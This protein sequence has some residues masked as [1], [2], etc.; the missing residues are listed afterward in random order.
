MVK[1]RVAKIFKLKDEYGYISPYQLEKRAKSKLPTFRFRNR[2][3][4]L[5][6]IEGV[7]ENTRYP[8]YPIHISCLYNDILR[9]SDTHHFYSCF[10]ADRSENIQPFLRCVHPDWAVIFVTD[11]SGKFMGRTWLRFNRRSHVD[12][13]SKTEEAFEIFKMYGNKLE[14]RDV[15]TLLEYLIKS[16]LNANI[17]EDKESGRQIRIKGGLSDDYLSFLD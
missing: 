13:T 10:H 12:W 2:L 4:E 11:K 9:A 14:E 6:A 17:V 5:R 8:D 1:K 3:H 16:R 7:Y 15:K